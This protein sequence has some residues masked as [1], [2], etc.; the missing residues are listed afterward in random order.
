[1][2][3][4]RIKKPPSKH[5]ASQSD[6]QHLQ[7]LVAEALKT[8]IQSGLNEGACNQA[9]IRNALTLLRDC[10][11]VPSADAEEQLSNLGSL[12]PQIKFVDHDFTA[13]RYE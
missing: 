12:M 6:L 3:R 9:A 1:M 2:A 8:E 13:A 10:D 5:G 4:S 7:A 11:I